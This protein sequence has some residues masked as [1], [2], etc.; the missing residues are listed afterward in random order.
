MRVQITSGQGPLECELAVKYL[1]ES[2]IKEYKDTSFI[3]V[4]IN[5]SSYCSGYTSIIFDTSEDLSFLQ[6]SVEWCCKSPLRPEHKRK[7]WFINVSILAN[8]TEI[9]KNGRI[10][11]QFFR[12]GGKGGQNVN[13]VETGVRLIHEATGITVSCTE[14]R[15]QLLN[16]KRA[17]E[18]LE[19]LIKEKRL[20]A[21]KK[22]SEEAWKQGKK[23]IR[24]NPIRIYKG[25]NFILS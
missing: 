11:W 20:E 14:E 5:K 3:P 16:R 1:Y 24:G 6:G 9:T 21:Q 17:I 23:L 2:L 15:S 8:C 12:S 4:L 10:F 22:Q 7:N 19:K 13:K 25:L 18:K